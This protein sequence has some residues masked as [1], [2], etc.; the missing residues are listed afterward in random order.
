MA[1]QVEIPLGLSRVEVSREEDRGNFLLFERGDGDGDH[2]E[3]VKRGR[4]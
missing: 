1:Q 3:R 2:L 4:A